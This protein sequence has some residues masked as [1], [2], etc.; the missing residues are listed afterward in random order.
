MCSCYSATSESAESPY[1]RVARVTRVLHTSCLCHQKSY[2]NVAWRVACHATMPGRPKRGSRWWAPTGCPAWMTKSEVDVLWKPEDDLEGEF[3]RAVAEQGESATARRKLMNY[4]IFNSTEIADWQEETDRASWYLRTT[5]SL[6]LL[7]LRSKVETYKSATYEERGSEDWMDRLFAASWPSAVAPQAAQSGSEADD[8]LSGIDDDS[9]SVANGD[10]SLVQ[11]ETNA[12]APQAAQS[13]SE[14]DDN[15][16]GNDD[17]DDEM[18]TAMGAAEHEQGTN[19]LPVSKGGASASSSAATWSSFAHASANTPSAVA[20]N[21]KAPAVTTA[22]F[23][24]QGYSIESGKTASKMPAFQVGHCTDL[25]ELLASSHKKARLTEAL[26]QEIE[27]KLKPLMDTGIIINES[28][29]QA[30]LGDKKEGN[31]GK[32]DSDNING[33]S[34]P[35]EATT[36]AVAA[37]VVAAV[38]APLLCLAITQYEIDFVTWDARLTISGKGLPPDT[39]GGGGEQQRADTWSEQSHACKDLL[40][41]ERRFTVFHEEQSPC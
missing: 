27:V 24:M 1:N 14:A 37:S 2:R 15:L 31:A 16:A 6:T 10:D 3:D 34:N 4:F 19:V 25:E 11:M 40:R 7:L 12:V 8:H 17:D 41:A 18:D 5:G 22:T 30:W 38:V 23:D 39:N 32:C 13:P 9:P 26:G 33:V 21:G 20:S 35:E 28:L 29:R 36:E